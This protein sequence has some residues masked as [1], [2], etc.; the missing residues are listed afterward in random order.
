MR[1]ESF[2]HH[3]QGLGQAGSDPSLR[4][5]TQENSYASFSS[6]VSSLSYYLTQVGKD[7]K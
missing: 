5:V 1:Q 3:G 6:A 2:G 7:T 4:T